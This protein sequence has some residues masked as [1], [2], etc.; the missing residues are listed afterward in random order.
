MSEIKRNFFKLCF[1]ILGWKVVGNPPKIKKYMITV[2][3]HTSGW[4]FLVGIAAKNIVGLEGQ[5][6]G[7]KSLFDLPIVGQ[8]MRYCGGHPVNRTTKSNVVDNVAEL[9][10]KNEEF[11]MVIAPEGTRNYQKEWKTG[12]YF[13]ALKAKIP[14]VMAGFDFKRKIVELK[15]PFMPTGDVL[16]DIEMMKEYYKT[17]TGKYPELGV[18]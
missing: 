2:A 16:K 11:V 9:F 4:D 17:V 18:H 1:W 6:L 10:Q 5:F 15:E 13:I 8:V 3:P 12:F 14:I 7:K